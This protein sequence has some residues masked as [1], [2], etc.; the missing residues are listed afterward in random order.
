MPVSKEYLAHILVRYAIKVNYDTF[1]DS[2]VW[3][4]KELVLGTYGNTYTLGAITLRVIL[5]GLFQRWK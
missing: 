5:V 1:P 2:V 3:K 4:T